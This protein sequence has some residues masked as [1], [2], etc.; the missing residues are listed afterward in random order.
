MK[1]YISGPITAKNHEQEV[2]NRSMFYE[3]AERIEHMGMEPVNPCESDDQVK[4]KTWINY[5]RKDIPLLLE[6]DEVWVIPNWYRSKGAN[7]EILI[8]TLLEI[9]IYCAETLKRIRLP[10]TYWFFD[11]SNIQLGDER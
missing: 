6:C 11:R 9:P 4:N 3:V 10:F 5:M 1:I 2:M 7:L 8:A